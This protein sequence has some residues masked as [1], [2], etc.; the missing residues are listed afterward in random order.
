MPQPRVE[1]IRSG[2]PNRP[3]EVLGQN[4]TPMTQ[5]RAFS[6]RGLASWYGRKFHG[7]RTASGEVYDMYAMTA[8]H[9]TLPIPSYARIRNP[10]NGREVIVRVNDR[11]PFHTGRIV[12]LSYTAALKLDVLRGVA[13]VELERITFAE[14]RSGA[15]R[16]D[17]GADGRGPCA[18]SRVPASPPAPPVPPA[19]AAAAAR[20]AAAA[21]RAAEAPRRR[22]AAA[23][24]G[25]RAAR[26]LDPARRVP[27]ARRRGELPA[28]RRRRARLAVAAARACSSTRRCSACR[29]APTRAARR[30]APAPSACARHCNSCR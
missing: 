11:G 21:P 18:G 30:H 28:P 12:D 6:E 20:D 5:D 10:A 15:W 4:Y 23:P 2:G 17:A 22:H 9:P 27:P 8:A 14:I 19:A 13:P 24:A 7:R 1:P 16:R 26:L 29:P 25:Q 3:Y